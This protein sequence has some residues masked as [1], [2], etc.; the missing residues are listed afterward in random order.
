MAA[1]L[2][3]I[4]ACRDRDQYADARVHPGEP[5]VRQ[6][7]G[8]VDTSTPEVRF[9]TRMLEHEQRLRSVLDQARARDLSDRTRRIVERA[10][11]QRLEHEADLTAAFEKYRGRGSPPS[12]PARAEPAVPLGQLQGAEYEKTLLRTLVA[13]YRG[14]VRDIESFLPGLSADITG[15]AKGDSEPATS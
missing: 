3:I 10:D 11:R 12:K 8:A 14:E 9:L 15:P 1:V 7:A 4:P 2:L 6:R 5:A 13:N